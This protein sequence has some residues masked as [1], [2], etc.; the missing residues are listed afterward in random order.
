MKFHFFATNFTSISGSSEIT[1]GRG[2]SIHILKAIFKTNSKIK[3]NFNSCSSKILKENDKKPHRI[4]NLY[5][6]NKKFSRQ[7][8]IVPLCWKFIHNLWL[9]CSPVL[10]VNVYLVQ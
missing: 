10:Q 7:L 3:R 9:E 1:K 6:T 2:K 5:A 8:S 4:N